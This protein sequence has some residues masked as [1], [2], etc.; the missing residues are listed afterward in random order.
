MIDQINELHPA[1]ARL[2]GYIHKHHWNGQA[3]AG[4][5][6]GVRLE[7]RVG[8]FL[9]SYLSFLPWSDNY[10]FMQTQGYWTLGN[11]LMA[12]LFNGRQYSS[13]ALACSDYVV[14][15][16]RP[17]GYWDYPPV[18]SRKNK[19]ATVEGNIAVIGLL[20]S[21]RRTQQESLL[22]AALKWHSFLFHKIGFQENEG[23]AAVNYWA[24]SSA[25][26]VPNNT[27]L[28]L[29]TLA[30][31]A[32][33]SRDEKYLKPCKALI[34]FLSQVQMASGEMPYV[35][36]NAQAKERPHFLC[37]QYNAFEFLDLA[38]YYRLTGDDKVWPILE[39]LAQFLATGVSTSGAAR[40]NC[41]HDK[42]EV[43]YYTVAVATALKRASALQLGDYRALAEKAYRWVLE[44]QGEDGR[45]NFF[46]RGNY[47]FLA[48]QRSYPRNLSMMLYHFLLEAPVHQLHTEP[49]PLK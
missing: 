20:A 42:P 12:D 24:D 1:I 39:K 6:S 31:L 11:W 27:T 15:R 14:S 36:A 21:Y 4:P 34:A 17:E 25:G 22:N 37:F 23:L 30:E 18:P 43:P 2:H 3:V 47:G 5:D 9:K 48:D 29:W 38:H 13:L 10:I 49:R 8:R 41:H 7:F 40:Y 16:Q 32:D 26:M 45:I 33:A 35:V 44:Q 19:I 28:T 46:S